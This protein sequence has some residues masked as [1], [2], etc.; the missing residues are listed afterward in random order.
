MKYYIKY[1]G[2]S[3]SISETKSYII[4]RLHSGL[5]N[6]LLKCFTL[7]S[8]AI[9]NNLNFHIDS[10]YDTSLQ[11]IHSDKKYF[12]FDKIYRKE[13]LNE[14]K[15]RNDS[16]KKE[17][18]KSL[19]NN[20]DI[21]T[22]YFYEDFWNNFFHNKDKIKQYIHIDQ[23]KV[24]LIRNKIK[25]SKK[26]LCLHYR[27]G[28]YLQYEDYNV[29]NI[30]YFKS[31]LSNFNLEDYQI[32]LFSDDITY[33]ID[34]LKEIEIEYKIADEYFNKDELS[35]HLMMALS[36]VVIC[37]NSTYSLSACILNEIFE[38]N[39][40]SKYTIPYIWKK[41]NPK[42]IEDR[43]SKNINEKFTIINF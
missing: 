41:N 25:C 28:D 16:I 4:T 8:L 2:G 29:L 39:R 36:D 15:I 18:G 38:F 33:A 14:L 24:D 1:Y 19:I 20:I 35:Q 43:L 3:S 12:Y 26:I 27:L 34:K 10:S 11:N 5:G 40:N 30:N 7:I 37:S 31:A 21:N 9:D 22:N 23:V 32:I 6:Q 42:F 17:G 13:N